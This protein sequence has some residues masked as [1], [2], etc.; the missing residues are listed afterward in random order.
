MNFEDLNDYEWA[1]LFK[2]FKWHLYWTPEANKGNDLP[3]LSPEGTLDYRCP[4]VFNF[5]VAI[6]PETGKKTI[7][8]SP[9]IGHNDKDVPHELPVTAEEF[10][11]FLITIASRFR[12]SKKIEKLWISIVTG[13]T[14]FLL[15]EMLREG[16]TN[17]IRLPTISVPLEIQ[18]GEYVL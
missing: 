2:K 18:E 6:M 5:R 11:D 14:L 7:N 16:K 13:A 10:I 4:V 9:K 1:A 3:M 8:V 12:D 15:F 17:G